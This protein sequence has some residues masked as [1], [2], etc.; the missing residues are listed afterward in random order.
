MKKIKTWGGAFALMILIVVAGCGGRSTSTSSSPA[1]HNEWTWIAGADVVDQVGTYGVQG[2]A[3][4]FNAPGAR[5]GPN[6]WTDA[7]GKF[8]LFGG[9]GAG[10][11]LSP[12]I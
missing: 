7:S 11:V 5:V 8:W 1:V 6:S 3:S 12:T 10:A 2:S 9:Y 4:S